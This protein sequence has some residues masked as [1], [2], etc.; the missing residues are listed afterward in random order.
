MA[1]VEKQTTTG[2]KSVNTIHNCY[3]EGHK[4]TE[5]LVNDPVNNFVSE[6]DERT[7]SDEKSC[8]RMKRALGD[9]SINK[10]CIPTCLPNCEHTA[11]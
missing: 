1:Q 9:V 2:L 6:V 7:K 8:T 10:E 11:S 5:R 3:S 4:R